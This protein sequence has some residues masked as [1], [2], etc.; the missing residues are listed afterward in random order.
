MVPVVDVEDPVAMIKREAHQDIVE[1]SGTIDVVHQTKIAMK[2][3]ENKT[4]HT[5]EW[6]L[7][8]SAWGMLVAVDCIEVLLYV[9]VID[10]RHLKEGKGSMNQSRGPM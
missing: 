4:T 1:V 5:D 7:L 8:L 10:M 9:P 6:L 2:E 3:G